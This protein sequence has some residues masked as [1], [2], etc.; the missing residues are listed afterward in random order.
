MMKRCNLS[1][2]F[3]F[4]V[5]IYVFLII[6]LTMSMTV[7][8]VVELWKGTK[9]F[10]NEDRLRAAKRNN[11]TA[12]ARHLAK[13]VFIEEAHKECSVMGCPCSS[14]GLVRPPLD[15]IGLTAIIGKFLTV[16]VFQWFLSADSLFGISSHFSHFL[17]RVTCCKSSHFNTEAAKFNALLTTSFVSGY[18]VHRCGSKG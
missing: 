6:L 10:K 16:V 11:V 14:N 12:L 15:P 2:E 1:F 3:L 5:V 17:F 18:C 4:A 7:T 8:Q 13:D 9:F